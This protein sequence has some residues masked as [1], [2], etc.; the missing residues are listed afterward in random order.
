MEPAVSPMPS[1][2]R[3]LYVA[4]RDRSFYR[5]QRFRDALASVAP[6]AEFCV[7]DRPGIAGYLGWLPRFFRSL[8][9]ADLVVAGFWGQ[10]LVPVIKLLT[11]K[12][13]LLDLYVLT[14]GRVALESDEMRRGP[15]AAIAFCIDRTALRQADLVTVHT[16]F[17]R[18]YYAVKHRVPRSK[19][20]PIPLSA[21]PVGREARPEHP[22]RDGVLRVHWHG[23]HLAH[24]GVTVILEA[25]ALLRGEPFH[26]TLVGGKGPGHGEHRARAA[27][28]KL[29]NVTF[30][31]DVSYEDLLRRMEAAAVCL[32]IFGTARRA[33]GVVSNKVIDAFA[34]RR[35]VVTGKNRATVAMLEG[36]DAVEFVPLGDPRAL[37]GALRALRE[38]PSRRRELAETGY[39]LY[40]KRFAAPAFARALG[41]IVHRLATLRP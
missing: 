20:V 17:H 37:A 14:H 4:T 16:E 32:G 39:R 18:R 23:R 35:A 22:A 41:G 29:D 5:T 27:A 26:F 25:A 34:V 24:H 8:R 28:R 10:P 21:G 31:G 11:G 9:R 36:H 30:V 38:D 3:I 15:R 40:R 7:P 12:P 6:G 1:Q 13:I 19:L 2:P 33:K